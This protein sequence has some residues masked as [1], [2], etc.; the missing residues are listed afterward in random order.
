[1]KQ[2]IKVT[3]ARGMQ[4]QLDRLDLRILDALHRDG[5]ITKKD[6]SE[7]VG[8]S[9][10][11][12]WERMRK[13]EQAG[14]IEGYHADLDLKR[15]FGVSYFFTQIRVRNYTFARQSRLEQLLARIDEILVGYSVMGS[16]DYFLIIL[17]RDIEHYQEVI[18]TIVS[19]P[20]ID[21]D[22]TTFPVTKVVKKPSRISFFELFSDLGEEE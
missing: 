4:Y 14:V 21:I 10:T 2:A 9:S 8:L 18:E 15:L 16:V 20:D 1:M 12:C 11:R 3:S 17:A 19:N 13:M 22:Y 7:Q 6:M 5:R